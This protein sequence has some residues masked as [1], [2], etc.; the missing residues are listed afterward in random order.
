MR[1][2]ENDEV[3]VVDGG[4]L[5][6]HR[7]VRGDVDGIRVLAES[8]CEHRRRCGFVLNDQNS[9]QTGSPPG[10]CVLAMVSAFAGAFR[11][12]AV[13]STPGPARSSV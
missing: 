10:A 2:V 7:A 6:G 3:V 5:E 12:P 1:I 13:R 11:T 9:H 4:V 8:L